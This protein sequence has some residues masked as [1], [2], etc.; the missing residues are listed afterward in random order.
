LEDN[1]INKS[2]KVSVIIVTWNSGEFINKCLSSLFKN[3]STLEYEVIVVDNGSLDG[4]I[5]KL[6]YDHNSVRIIRNQHN[7]GFA[8][9]NNIGIFNACAKTL[10]LLNPDVTPQV[11]SIQK[12][13]ELLWSDFKIGAVGGKL[14]GEN[15]EVQVGFNVRAFPTLISVAFDLLLINKIFIRN[16]INN[17]YRLLKMDYSK[18]QEVDQPAAA[19]LMLK[20][21][22]IDIIGLFDERFFPAWFE[23]VDLCRRIKQGGW[24]IMYH[25]GAEFIHVGSHSLDNLSVSD[26]LLSYYRNM[27]RYFKKN[28][29][30]M[31]SCIVRILIIFGMVARI[32][33][34]VSNFRDNSKNRK[35]LWN[36]Y[37][38]ILVKC[39]Q[40][41]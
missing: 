7:L 29:G 37:G 32:I 16:P 35:E 12:L 23:D 8:K 18:C 33:G 40:G 17:M 31:V 22:V 3:E 26:F 36:A 34:S 27:T 39:F 10:F 19:C 4:S 21:E 20:K 28:Q 24:R 5:D 41:L 14:I 2:L 13:Y 15:G 6:D 1:K 11:S 9:A 38:N 25:P 30:L